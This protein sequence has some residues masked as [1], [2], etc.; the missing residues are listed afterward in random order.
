[1]RSHETSVPSR[2]PLLVFDGDCGFC[3][4]AVEALR[5]RLPRFP[6]ATPW[7]WIELDA[8]GLSADDV[9]DYAW[10]ISPSHHY[11]GH[12]ALSALLRMQR[13]PLLRV[14][15]ALLA[16]PPFSWAGALGYRWIA[17]NRHRLPGGTP[18]CALPRS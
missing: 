1:M 16:T 9:R 5:R 8:Y 15:G 11:G 10:V 2:S 18:A 14:A 6:E 7:Q 13:S 12:L 17:A 3:T 4:T